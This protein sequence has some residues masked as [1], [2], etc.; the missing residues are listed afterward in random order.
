[1][2]YIFTFSLLLSLA[3]AQ[4]NHGSHQHG[5]SHSHSS[6]HD[7]SSPANI[8][9]QDGLSF[10]IEPLI[11]HP[12]GEDAAIY[13]YIA[14][15]LNDAPA[16]TC[17]IHNP[18]GHSAKN[19]KSDGTKPCTIGFEGAAFEAGRYSIMLSSQDTMLMTA[20]LLEHAQMD[21]GTDIYSAFMP[22]PSMAS[23]GKSDL[24]VYAIRDGKNVHGD[25]STNY[26]MEGMQHSTDDTHFVLEHQHLDDTFMTNRATL[27]FPM[28]GA[29]QTTVTVDE[30]Q[31]DFVLDVTETPEQDAM[32]AMH[33]MASHQHE[34][35]MQD[36]QLDF[37]AMVGD[38]AVSCEQSYEGLGLS[39]ES[40]RFSDFR[41]YV[42][43]V[44]LINEA[45]EAV[46][47]MLEQDSPWQYQNVALLDFE[48]AEGACKGNAAMNSSIL[49]KVPEGSYQAIAFTLGVPESLNHEDAAVA[50]SPLN[51]TPMWWIWR[52]GY[53]FVR[54]DIENSQGE[55]NTQNNAWPLHLGS[56]GCGEGEYTEAPS[57]ACIYPNRVEVQLPFAIDDD[58]V[59]ADVASLLQLS[60]VSRSFKLEPPGCMSGNDDPDC[61]GVFRQLGLDLQTGQCFN[62]DCSSQR[63]FS[64]A[65]KN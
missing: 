30:Q 52:F 37:R 8:F 21:D 61:R 29:W 1:M 20:A 60:D 2:R 62:G 3:F 48:N 43:D 47:V 27:Q 46:M 31:V 63:F 53:K 34:P 28:L 19:V 6:Q 26:R 57:V 58:V 45:G 10:V 9:S 49:G 11:L 25:M 59:V 38:E 15:T 13:F 54:I 64:R 51:I 23:R 55:D 41:F 12:E 56:T 14:S 17:E 22:A 50:E 32:P 33:D 5:S 40:I 39:G 16:F 65:S 7:Q 42:H 24:F 35:T 4:H 36:V 18:S 44:Q